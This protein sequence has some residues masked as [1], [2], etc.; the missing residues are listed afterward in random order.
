M[1]EK[2]FSRPSTIRA[3][4]D[5]P[6]R[7]ERLYHLEQCVRAGASKASLQVLAR[8][9]LEL[10]NALDLQSAESVSRVE[11]QS[12]AD[13]RSNCAEAQKGWRWSA[14]KAN[15]FVALA[16]G[17]LRFTGRLEEPGQLCPQD[18]GRLVRFVQFMQHD[19]EWAAETVRTRRYAAIRFLK[20]L[21]QRNICFAQ[22]SVE[23]VDEYLASL[24]ALN[25]CSRNSMHFYARCLRIFLRFA[26]QQHWC[27]AA[28]SDNIIP[29]GFLPDTG[30][31]KGVSR[32]EVVD[33]L[34][35]TEGSRPADKRARAIIMVLV[36]YALRAGEVCGLLLDDI[37][38]RR[39]TLTVRCPKPGQ[40]HTYPLSPNV[41]EA[42]IG[43]LRDVRPACAHREVFTT[44][45]SPYRPLNSPSLY[46]IVAQRMKKIGISG[47]RKGPHSLRHATAQHLLNQG[48]Q[49]KEVGDYLGHRSVESTSVYAK[50][51]LTALRKV[52]DFDLE[53]LR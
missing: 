23:Q 20:W 42:I 18:E 32:Q 2:I 29:P 21:R 13:H 14:Q 12:I 8:V 1:F 9:Q 16:V 46:F 19:C 49:M 45:L 37:D 17:F 11:V 24:K 15:R 51:N 36:T 3:Y 53:V 31:P 4:S 6:L 52:A 48:L 38:W 40:V 41:G 28:I 35:A 22:L 5:G 43:Y 47:A 50:V 26:A 44:L 25:G 30:I 34:A 7:E 10:V 39:N 27:D 33:L